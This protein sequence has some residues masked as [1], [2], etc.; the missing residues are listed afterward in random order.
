[1][2]FT[3]F[4]CFRLARKS[5]RNPDIH[6]LGVGRLLEE[7][8]STLELFLAEAAIAKL[9]HPTVECMATCKGAF[10]RGRAVRR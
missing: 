2:P 6:A 5:H 9:F 7:Y 8:K 1:M 10:A 3:V 4:F